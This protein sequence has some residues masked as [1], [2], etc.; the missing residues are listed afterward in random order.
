MEY[1]RAEMRGESLVDSMEKR[2][3]VLMV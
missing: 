1:E 2:M 3:V